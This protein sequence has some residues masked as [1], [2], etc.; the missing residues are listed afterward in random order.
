MTNRVF[1]LLFLSFCLF[2]P[3][4]L[5]AADTAIIDR[6]QNRYAQTDAFDAN[7]EQTL[8]HKESGTSETRKGRLQFQ[9][10][11]LI[12]WQTEKPHE[13]TLVVTGKEIWDYLP[14]EELAYRYNPAL[15]QDSRSI[16]QVLTGQSALNRDFEVKGSTREQN[17]VKL[18]LFPNEPTPQLVEA[19]I[20]VDPETGFIR[21]ANIVDFY[22]NSNDVK[23][24]RFEPKQSIAPGQF[25]FSPPK[26]VEVEDLMDKDIG[27]RALFK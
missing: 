2:V 8:T 11:L 7:F 21:R 12:R 14:D 5:Y 24:G 23:F 20:W 1:I 6:I 18:H 22:G 27:E 4:G 19:W 13:E 15:V 9:K 26:G 3:E 10:P 25:R 16:I 17:L